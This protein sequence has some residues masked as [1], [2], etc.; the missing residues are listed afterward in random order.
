[1]GVWLTYRP[2]QFKI[3]HCCT[4][5]P[6]KTHTFLIFQNNSV[7][8]K[9]SWIIF[10]SRNPKE[11]WHD[12]WLR[13]CPWGLHLKNIT[14]CHHVKCR[15][16]QQ[17]ATATRPHPGLVLDTFSCMHYSESYWSYIASLNKSS[18]VAEMG[19]RLATIDMG[20]KVVELLCRLFGGGANIGWQWH[21]SYHI[22]ASCFLAML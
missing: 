13:S 11:F 8:N 14:A 21:T 3:S 17:D 22:Y 9:P 20:R 1:M 5:C 16:H 18:A 19:D 12:N 4:V 15:T 6:Y 7:K 2:T 10:G